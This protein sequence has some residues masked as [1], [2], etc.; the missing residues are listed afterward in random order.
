MSERETPDV[1]GWELGASRE[2]LAER[3]RQVRVVETS[4]PE[5]LRMRHELG[6]RWRVV[7]QSEQDGEIVLVAAREIELVVAGG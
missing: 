1:T 6:E 4:P 5:R 2:R 7:R 3:G